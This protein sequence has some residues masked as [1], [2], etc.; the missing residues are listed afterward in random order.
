MQHFISDLFNTKLDII[1]LYVQYMFYTFIYTCYILYSLACEVL[2]SL[3]DIASHSLPRIIFFLFEVHPFQGI[4]VS[5]YQ[6]YIES[7]FALMFFT[8]I[9]EKL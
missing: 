2:F 9:L 6:R 1:V 7:L 4:L 3:F 5:V 8:I